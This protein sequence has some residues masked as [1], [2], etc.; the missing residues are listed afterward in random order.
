MKPVAILSACRT[1]IGKFGGGLAELSAVDLG[2]VAVEESL[3]RAG[4]APDQVELAIVGL[5][6]QAGC[7]PNPARQIAVRA[8]IPVTSPSYTLNQACASGLAALGMAA[9]HIALGEA[10]VVIAAGAESMSN[11]PY[12]LPAARWGLRL[13][14]RKLVD[15]MY[16]DGF[17]CPLADMIMGETAEVV[18]NELGIDR[19][20]QDEY[21][22]TSQ[23]RCQQA[24]E[25]GRFEAELV[26]VKTRKAVVSADEHPRANVTA[27]KLARLDPVFSKEG[28]ITA[29]NASGI[30]DGA[31][32]LVVCSQEYV[33]THG[34]KPMAW[35]T[36]GKTVGLDPVR[37]GLGPVHA[38]RAFFANGGGKLE[39]Y[40]L[41]ELNEAFAA[42]VLACHAQMPLPLER[43]NV[44]GG[45]IALGH[46]IG[47]TGN[48][49]V[50]TLLH[51]MQRRQAAKGLA[52]LCVSGGLGICASFDNA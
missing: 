2:V 30:T 6:R 51:E 9:R 8:G 23:N 46:P 1:P 37:M 20:A 5:A 44:N 33:K 50:V 19:A 3:K 42:Q 48:R 26:A 13:G 45:A 28:T 15:G 47:C 12:L 31:S 25:A 21:A 34:L 36:G 29:G 49:I 32:S 40:D 7:G 22:A 39:D 38:M 52:T 14:H 35:Y 10:Q 18:A 11:V 4:V 16:Q 43:V 24:T 27:E 41:I 17:F